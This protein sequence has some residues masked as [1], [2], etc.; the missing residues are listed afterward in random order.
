MSCAFVRKCHFQMVVKPIRP[1]AARLNAGF[2]LSGQ[3]TLRLQRGAIALFEHSKISKT[4]HPLMLNPCGRDQQCK[5][6]P[7]PRGVAFTVSL[8]RW[9]GCGTGF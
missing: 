4:I 8:D 1:D 6:D 9:R 3:D 5:I 7:W 2:S